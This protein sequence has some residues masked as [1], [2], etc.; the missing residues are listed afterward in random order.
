MI[1]IL[2]KTSL[3]DNKQM[4]KEKKKEKKKNRP[5]TMEESISDIK[6]I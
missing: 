2:Y 3:P 5:E 4:A 6:L 1:S